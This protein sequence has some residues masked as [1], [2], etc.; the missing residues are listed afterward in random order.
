MDNQPVQPP[1]PLLGRPETIDCNRKTHGD[2]T[3]LLGDSLAYCAE[4]GKSVNGYMENQMIAMV[5]T[6]VR[7]PIR[8]F[9]CRGHC[10]GITLRS[11]GN[12]FLDA[13]RHGFEHP[14]EYPFVERVEYIPVENAG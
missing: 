12:R 6:S 10:L 7:R 11:R 1:K 13:F 4:L 8:Q 5:C 14:V 3:I 9:T 2:H